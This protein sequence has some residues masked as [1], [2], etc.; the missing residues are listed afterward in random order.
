MR[1]IFLV[2]I[3]ALILP[4]MA[5]AAWKGNQAANARTEVPNDYWFNHRIVETDSPPT[6]GQSAIDAD[7]TMQWY[8]TD[9]YANMMRAWA[10]VKGEDGNV[11]IVSKDTEFMRDHYD[12]PFPVAPIR[13]TYGVDLVDDDMN[14]VVDDLAGVRFYPSLYTPPGND[15]SP[16]GTEPEQHGTNMIGIAVAKTD[17]ESWWPANDPDRDSGYFPGIAGITWGCGYYGIRG[18][19]STK[20]AKFT[21]RNI[22]NGMNIKVASCSWS[23]VTR[24]YA[25]LM[26]ACGVLLVAAG[27]NDRWEVESA[28]GFGTTLTVGCVDKEYIRSNWNGEGSSS[29]R[30]DSGTA[31]DICG[32]APSASPG[33]FYNWTTDEYV[34]KS[35]SDNDVSPYTIGYSM[36]EDAAW[37]LTGDSQEYRALSGIGDIDTT[38]YGTESNPIRVATLMPSIIESSGCAAQVAGVT[39]LVATAFPGLTPMQLKNAVLRGA[40]PIDSY[41]TTECCDGA[42]IGDCW[43]GTTETRDSDCAGLLGAGRVDAYR[44]V[45]LWGSVQDTTLSGDIYVSGDVA[46]KGI[47]NIAAGTKFYIAP[48]DITNIDPWDAGTYNMGTGVV[49]YFSQAVGYEDEIQIIAFPGSTVNING[50]ATNPVIFDSFVEGAQGTDDWVGLYNGFGMAT[51]N[52]VAGGFQLLHSTYDTIQ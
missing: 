8:L 3:A 13:E 10:V 17:N 5:T 11:I 15:P 50:T 23:G 43:N 25:E 28:G 35:W 34:I 24:E 38:A 1:R 45:T 37:M 16:D 26:D 2:V 46:L 49:T 9:D 19:P 48:D 7:H 6:E 21:A 27:G 12:L 14:G 22:Y 29:Y 18:D 4:S 30:Q 42:T 47:V 33:N 32:Y 51:I 31:L 40:V 20:D 41:N 52:Y 36:K 44:A 39:A